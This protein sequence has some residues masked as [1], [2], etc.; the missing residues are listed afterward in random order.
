MFLSAAFWLW[1]VVCLDLPARFWWFFGIELALGVLLAFLL[2]RALALTPPPEPK[3]WRRSLFDRLYGGFFARLERWGIR[4]YHLWPPL[5]GSIGTGGLRRELRANNLH[6]LPGDVPDSAENRLEPDPSNQPS[7]LPPWDES[8]R[9]N[10][11]P[12]GSYNDLSEPAMGMVG[13]RFGR[14]VPAAETWPTVPP[15][16]DPQRGI[17]NPAR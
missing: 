14:N 7:P 13:M 12:D 3:P 9:D 6:A 17:P 4:W 8:Y 10:R 11:S 1:A 15:E 2:F 16:G 5:F